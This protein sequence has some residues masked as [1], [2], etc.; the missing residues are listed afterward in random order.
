MSAYFCIKTLPPRTSDKI[1]SSVLMSLSVGIPNNDTKCVL[2]IVL[3]FSKKPL[4]SFMS[5]IVVK[6]LF[7]FSPLLSDFLNQL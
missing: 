5:P 2:F 4:M 3:Y 7:I 6:T 1:K